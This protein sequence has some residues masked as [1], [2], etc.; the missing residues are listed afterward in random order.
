MSGDIERHDRG[1]TYLQLLRNPTFVLLWSGQ[2][3]STIGDAVFNVAVM[4]LVYVQTG[5]A[6]RTGIISVL[7]TL[8]SV[9]IGP[10]A[11]VYADRW[12]RKWTMAGVAF[13]SAVI[14]SVVTIP[15]ALAGFSPPLIYV[16]VVLLNVGAMFYSPARSSVMPEIV[17]RDLM[18]AAGGLFSL[19]NQ[20]TSLIGAALAGLILAVLG[21][22]WA[23]VADAGSFLVAA[24]AIAVAHIPG[25]ARWS[26]SLGRPSLVHDLRDGWRVARGHPVL[27]AFIRIAALVNVISYMGPL[28]PALV[29][30]Q[31]HGDVKA[32]GFLEA[33]SV[34]GGMAGGLAAGS[35]ERRVGTGRLISMSF[36]VGG[37]CFTALGISSSVL[38]G[39]ALFL[40]ATFFL[41]AADVS[42]GALMPL[43][44]PE[45]YRGRVS[46]LLRA[47]AVVAMPATILL[48][49]WLADRV[50]PG[51]LYVFGGLWAVGVGFLAWSSPHLRTARITL[52]AEG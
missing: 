33:A 36:T 39:G 30:L 9:I 19:A 50:G 14:V 52:R 29:R 47:T 31:M 43:L 38:L 13:L 2:T 32:Y 49:G 10:I 1:G 21:A 25:H 11:G 22:T 8:S 37:L 18:A 40:T 51:P 12:N 34:V 44:I 3:I 41:I 23:L 5:S 24:I 35:L 20:G 6:L 4:W 16:T 48:G 42:M 46:G 17:G 15:L 26:G 28:F 27:W 7:Y 45:E